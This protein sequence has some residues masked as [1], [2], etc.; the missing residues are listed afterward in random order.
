L[1]LYASTEKGGPDLATKTTI[2]CEKSSGNVFA[3]LGLPHP[4][5]EFLKAR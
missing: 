2:A 1:P 5:R 3:D 4:E